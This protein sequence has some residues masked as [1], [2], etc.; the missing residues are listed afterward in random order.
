MFGFKALSSFL[1]GTLLLEQGSAARIDIAK[2]KGFHPNLR[3]SLAKRGPV[4]AA[5]AAPEDYQYYNDGSKRQC[6][7]LF[8]LRRRLNQTSSIFR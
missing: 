7:L 8:S 1:L 4:H 5:R 6:G 3:N 2:N